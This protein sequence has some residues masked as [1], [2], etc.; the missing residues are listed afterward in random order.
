MISREYSWCSK[1]SVTESSEDHKVVVLEDEHVNGSEVSAKLFSVL[2]QC[3]AVC[4]HLVPPERET[5]KVVSIYVDAGT[6]WLE[7]RVPGPNGRD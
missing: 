7:S 6:D 5:S 3:L 1:W 2:E 4:R